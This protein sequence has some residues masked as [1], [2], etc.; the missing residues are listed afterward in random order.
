TG[1]TDSESI[2]YHDNSPSH[3]K[4]R[5][6]N[7]DFTQ[8]LSKSTHIEAGVKNSQVNSD[9][10]IGFQQRTDT[11]DVNVSS[12]TDHF[13][14][15]EQINSAYLKLETKFNKTDLSFS[16][17]GE[18]TNTTTHSINPERISDTSYFNLFPSVQL[19]QAL[20]KNNTFTAFYTRNINRPNYQDL[21]PFVGY[22]DQFYYSTGNPFLK[23]SYV[24][25]YQVSDLYLNKYKV[26]LSMVV[27]DNYFYTIFEQDDATKVYIVTKANLG[28]RYQYLAQFNIPIDIPRWWNIDADLTAYHERYVYKNYPAAQKNTNGILLTLSQ[29]FKLTSKLTAQV[30]S[31]YESPSYFAISQYQTLYYVNAG[32]KYSVLKNNG[33]IRLSVSD[34]FNSDMNQYHTSF[35]NLDITARDKIGSRFVQAAFTYHFGNLSIKAHQ[36]KAHNEEIKRLSDSGNEN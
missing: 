36:S 18:G 25:T 12:L 17:R 22:V 26:S 4:I 19:V 35:S 5:S 7:I 10:L 33:S 3:I 1:Q 23:P 28:T 21:N 9:N 2:F 6:E 16:L 8:M 32:L 14:Y 34:I 27:T 13:V 31:D 29:N 24:N 20:D 15:N 30:N 11:G